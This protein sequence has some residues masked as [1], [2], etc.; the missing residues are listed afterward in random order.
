ME[1]GSV[2]KDIDLIFA[3]LTREGDDIRYNNMANLLT[4][5]MFTN[6]NSLLFRQHTVNQYFCV[7]CRV[8]YGTLPCHS[9]ALIA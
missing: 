9:T 2:W 7:F 4:E 5:K 1:F 3:L 8:Q 6:H